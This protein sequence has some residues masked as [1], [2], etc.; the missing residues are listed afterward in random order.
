MGEPIKTIYWQQ[1]RDGRGLLLDSK[2]KRGDQRPPRKFGYESAA[3]IDADFPL[4]TKLSD[5]W[6]WSALQ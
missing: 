1:H 6:R 2:H 3:L 4:R 5:G